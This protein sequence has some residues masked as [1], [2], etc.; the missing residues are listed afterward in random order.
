MV[1]VAKRGGSGAKA[2]AYLLSRPADGHTLL[3]LTQTH[4]YTIARGRSKLGI[5]DIVGVARAMDDPTL[6]A[7]GG[8]S[9]FATIEELIAAS[10]EKPLNWGVAVIASTEHI[11]LARFAKATGI[12][13][14][15]IPFGSGAQMV[16]QLMSGAVDVTLPNVSEAIGPLADGSVRALAVMSDKRLADYPDVPTTFEKGIEIKTSTT[17]GYGVLKGTPQAVIER[18]SAALTKAMR[19]QKFADYLKSSG[20]TP[21]DSVAGSEV[22]DRQLKEEYATAA[23][24]LKELGFTK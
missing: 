8:T 4:L 17:R 6:I 13:Y 18:L 12:K 3:A 14:K 15:V 1:V 24:A 21:A 7:V 5:D 11:G 10:M 22:W 20:L 19:G 23:R 16:Q 9:P 2:H